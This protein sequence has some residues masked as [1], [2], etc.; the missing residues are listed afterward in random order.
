MEPR[1]VAFTPP[2][3]DRAVYHSFVAPTRMLQS[4]HCC[5]GNQS[6]THI[7][8]FSFCLSSLKRNETLRYW[9]K[10]TEK[11]TKYWWR[12]RNGACLWLWLGFNNAVHKKTGMSMWQNTEQYQ[13]KKRILLEEA[14]LLL[15]EHRA[16]TDLTSTFF[17]PSKQLSTRALDFYNLGGR[18][19][20]DSGWCLASCPRLSFGSKLK[21]LAKYLSK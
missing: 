17:T 5:H 18:D 3:L 10:V 7:Q 9:K 14:F 8:T 12:A 1:L 15:H 6:K 20:T 19:G 2:S 21:P 13:T 16:V 11:E 4:F